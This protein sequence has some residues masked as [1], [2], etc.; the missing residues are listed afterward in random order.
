MK[1][2]RETFQIKGLYTV[3]RKLTT[4]HYGRETFQI[5]GLYTKKYILMKR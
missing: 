3:A 5:K 2:G 4:D 1:M